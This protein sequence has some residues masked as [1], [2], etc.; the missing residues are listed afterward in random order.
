MDLLRGR[1]LHNLSRS[2]RVVE[3]ISNFA[4]QSFRPD[5]EVLLTSQTAPVL[6]AS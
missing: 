2:H 6:F 5:A 1:P 3:R 4:A